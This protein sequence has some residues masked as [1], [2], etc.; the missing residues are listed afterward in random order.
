MPLVAA[1]VRMGGGLSSAIA[2]LVLLLVDGPP[3]IGTPWV[4]ATLVVDDL[5]S[6]VEGVFESG[7]FGKSGSRG[8]LF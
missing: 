3:P 6:E 4:G 1:R 2:S 8:R 5:F 7:S